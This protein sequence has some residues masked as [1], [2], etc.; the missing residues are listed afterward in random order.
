MWLLAFVGS[1][2]LLLI[3]ICIAALIWSH[4]AVLRGATASPDDYH[5]VYD[6]PASESRAAARRVF[7]NAPSPLDA[8]LSR[9]IEPLLEKFVTASNAQD[10]EAFLQLVARER[11]FAEMKRCPA[12]ALVENVQ[13]LMAKYTLDQR[14]H[15]PMVCNRYEIRAIEPVREL[16]HT[17]KNDNDAKVA[18][19]N[20]YVV[21]TEMYWG[22]SEACKVRWWVT[23][24]Q[25]KW[26]L[27]D[28]Q[29]LDYGGQATREEAMYL[30]LEGDSRLADYFRAK[31]TINASAAE[32]AVGNRDEAVRLLST[33]ARLEV[34]PIFRDG[35][36]LQIAS[37]FSRMGDVMAA[38]GWY[39]RIEHPELLPAS[40][41]GKTHCL[42]ALQRWEEAIECAKQYE[43]ISGPAPHVNLR[44]ARWLHEMGRTEEAQEIVRRLMIARPNAAS[45]GNSNASTTNPGHANPS[46]LR[47]HTK[48]DADR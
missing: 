38:L 22:D 35:T 21:Y 41:A 4:S 23:R 32:M 36:N 44:A 43:S 25:G 5:L 34:P 16:R 8:E 9:S 27:Y 29:L 26:Q 3:G 6:E 15:L 2:L 46:P 19:D 28:W 1:G 24:R 12:M 40:L 18:N 11:F 10:Q 31:A 14:L 20:E 42:G 39:E 17:K 13:A 45:A 47:E 7:A 48:L 30:A 33:A 37:T